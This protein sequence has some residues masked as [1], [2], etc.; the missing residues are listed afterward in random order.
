MKTLVL[1]FSTKAYGCYCPEKTVSFHNTLC[2]LRTYKAFWDHSPEKG[3]GVCVCVPIPVVRH[4]TQVTWL[5]H[6]DCPDHLLEVRQ[7]LAD[8]GRYK[9]STWPW[10]TMGKSFLSPRDPVASE[11]T[12]LHT[13]HRSPQISLSSWAICWYITDISSQVDLDLTTVAG[14]QATGPRLSKRAVVQTSE[15]SSWAWVPNLP[16]ANYVTLGKPDFP[17]L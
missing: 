5:E 14:F 9:V 10:G 1:N 3:M 12:L 7:V 16:F 15:H 17:R 8:W 4:A 6:G 13:A 11:T 2:S